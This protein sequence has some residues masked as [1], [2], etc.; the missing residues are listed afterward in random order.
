MTK[1]SRR[2]VSAAAAYI[3]NAVVYNYDDQQVCTESISKVIIFKTNGL[4]EIADEG[5]DFASKVEKSNEVHIVLLNGEI[6]LTAVL[7]LDDS[8]SNK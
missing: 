5:Q 6:T 7:T 3:E 8:H 1:N 4:N 2:Q